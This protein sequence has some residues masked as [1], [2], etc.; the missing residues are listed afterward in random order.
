MCYRPAART[1]WRLFL[2]VVGNTEAL[3]SQSWS[4][5]Q[6]DTQFNSKQFSQ[7]KCKSCEWTR[8]SKPLLLSEFLKRTSCSFVHAVCS[9]LCYKRVTNFFPNAN[10]IDRWKFGS[11]K[12]E[13]ADLVAAEQLES[14][15]SANT[16]CLTAHATSVSWDGVLPNPYLFISHII[17]LEASFNNQ[18]IIQQHNG[19]SD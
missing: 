11:K 13:E 10:N 17:S 2:H 9:C 12:V 14:T 5:K 8:D 18:L 15:R 6:Y 7:K 3:T 16:A 1:F 4:T 19:Y